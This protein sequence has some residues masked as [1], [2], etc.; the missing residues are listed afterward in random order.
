MTSKDLISQYVDTGLQLP[1]YQVMKLS[2]QDKRTYI[3]K[4]FIAIKQSGNNL[5]DYEFKIL[6]TDMQLEYG[7]TLIKRNRYLNDEQINMLSPETQTEYITSLAKYNMRISDKKI[8]LLSPELQRELVQYMIF[9]IIPNKTISDHQLSLVPLEIQRQY[10]FRLTKNN[11]PIND[12]QFSLLT[13]EEQREYAFKRANRREDLTVNQFNSLSFD[14]QVE[15]L[16]VLIK[17]NVFI[18]YS[19][20]IE[21]WPLNNKIELSIK[22]AENG[23]R[24]YDRVFYQLPK[25]IQY[26]IV[27]MLKK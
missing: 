4:R 23:K 5:S 6:P 27:Q 9:K 21:K 3:R 26:K 22:A 12:Y 17:N 18:P 16:I 8:G 19:D 1:E 10:I 25:N 14:D 2:N 11:D 7:I 24:I 15:F 20:E 13:P